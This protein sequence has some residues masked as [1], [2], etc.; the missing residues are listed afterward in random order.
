MPMLL[1]VPL[2]LALA[3]C[4]SYPQRTAQAFDGFRRGDFDTAVELYADPKTTGSPFL[5][6]AEVGMVALASGDWERAQAGFDRAAEEVREVED[7]A[8]V[9]AEALGEELLAFTLNESMS[10]YAGEGYERVQ[11]HACLALTYLARGNLDGVWVE[12]Q[13]ANKLLEKEEELYETKYQAGGLGH[14]V[15]ALSYELQER[16]DEAYIDYLRMEEKGVG[17]EL[18]G[19]AL[20][21]LGTRMRDTER[22]PGFI[23]RYGDD[24]ELPDGAASIVLIGAVGLAPYKVAKTLTIPTGDGLLQWSVPGYVSHP[25][26]QSV[27]E[28]GITGASSVRAS[29]LEDIDRVSRENL[30]DRLL[31]LA[32]RTAVRSLLKRELTQELQRK[33]EVVGFIAG[34]L[35]TVL[36]EQADT[37]AWQTL[38]RAWQAARLWVEPGQHE[39]VLRGKRESVSLGT[40][41]VDP[42]ETVI[43]LVRELDGTL[44]PH[45]I[46]GLRIDV[47]PPAPTLEDVASPNI[48]P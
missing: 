27:L 18:T 2:L 41:G 20:V 31:W 44:Y 24:L 5:A 29:V 46:G 32:A 15:S 28:L 22:L 25:D 12:T 7:R 47:P 34:S 14:F 33:H 35:F 8:L 38:P 40:Y 11:L 19:R 39:L 13:R 23:E 4:R 37:R 48:E 9:S 21:R 3:S 26:E 16:F 1:L 45:V 36:T 10:P 43:V 6:G 42:K 17:V 30:D